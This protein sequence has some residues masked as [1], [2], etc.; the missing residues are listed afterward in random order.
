M[1]A[2][3]WA[4]WV[5]A[6]T[7]IAALVVS[8]LAYVRSGTSISE[9]KRSADQAERS[10]DHAGE[11]VEEARQLR[12]IEADRRKEERQRRH[13]DLAPRV[14]EEFEVEFVPN[15]LRG[16]GYGDLFV[17]LTA[18]DR[19]YRARAFAQQG[20]SSTERSLGTLV[21]EARQTVRLHLEPWHAEQQEPVTDVVVLKF[22]P[23]VEGPDG[24]SVWECGCGR[25]GGAVMDGAGH[26]ERR[27]KVSY[28]P[29][30]DPWAAYT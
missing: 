7:G 21:V 19:S 16:D 30:P 24:T 1:E 14:P 29:G 27:V 15:S 9:A 4:A 18:N 6:L 10:A 3:D 25:P 28:S 22:W 20:A 11:A 8:V 5:A 23:P 26:W 13:D 12:E 2:A 17:T